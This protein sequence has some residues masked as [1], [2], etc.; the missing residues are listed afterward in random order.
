MEFRLP[1]ERPR[2]GVSGY[3]FSHIANAVESMQ[4]QPPLSTFLHQLTNPAKLFHSS[5]VKRVNRERW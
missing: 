1:A 4:L 2:G 3:G 5:Y